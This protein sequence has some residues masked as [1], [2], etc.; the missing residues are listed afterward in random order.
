LG[1]MCDT[2]ILNDAYNFFFLL[3]VLLASWNFLFN[4]YLIYLLTYLF[5]YLKGKS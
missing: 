1:S 5:R 2:H 4:F 3:L